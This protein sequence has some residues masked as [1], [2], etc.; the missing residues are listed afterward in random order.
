MLEKEKEMKQQDGE[1]EETE[2]VYTDSS[3]FLKVMRRADR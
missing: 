3:A 2:T 1:E